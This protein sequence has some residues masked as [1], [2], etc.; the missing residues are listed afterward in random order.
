MS[1]DKA[2]LEGG[3]DELAGRIVAVETAGED[4]KITFRNGHEHYRP[5][6]RR[7]DTPE[8]VLPVY[9]WWERTEMPG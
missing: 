8:G 6:S 1:S 5:T 9:E 2:I 4:V 3:P 7:A